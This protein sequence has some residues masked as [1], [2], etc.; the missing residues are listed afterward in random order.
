VKL[1]FIGPGKP[2]EN[3]FIESFNGRLRDEYLNASLFFHVEDARQKF[4]T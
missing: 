3:A 4:E 2:C 1:D